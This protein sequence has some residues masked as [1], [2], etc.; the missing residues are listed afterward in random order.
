[1]TL[2]IKLN[3]RVFEEGLGELL[4]SAVAGIPISMTWIPLTILPIVPET[5]DS[6]EAIKIITNPGCA[7]F[8]VFLFPPLSFPV[9]DGPVLSPILSLSGLLG[10]LGL[11][12]LLDPVPQTPRHLDTWKEG[13]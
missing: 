10:L 13:R 3:F 11:R 2:I 4:C 1:M 7:K 6:W 5:C 8:G 9:C 12:S